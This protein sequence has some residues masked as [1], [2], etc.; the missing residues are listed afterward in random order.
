M[1]EVTSSNL[2]KRKNGHTVVKL[3]LLVEGLARGVR[4]V[5]VPQ[6]ELMAIQT[7]HLAPDS[8]VAVFHPRRRMVL[9]DAWIGEELLEEDLLGAEGAGRAFVHHL[10]DLSAGPE[11]EGVELGGANRS[12]RL[13]TEK[14]LH[15]APRVVRC[16]EALELHLV[17]LARCESNQRS[18]RREG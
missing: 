7:P 3:G 4:C 5:S 15:D 12:V 18:V 11:L 14:A 8:S 17:L 16:D 1:D 6:K 10:G 9:D 13:V 2:Q